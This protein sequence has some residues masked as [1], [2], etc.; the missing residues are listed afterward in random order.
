MAEKVDIWEATLGVGKGIIIKNVL[1]MLIPVTV[2]ELMGAIDKIN[3]AE[4][5]GPLLDPSAWVDGARWKNA[6]EAKNVLEA[7]AELRKTLTERL[8]IT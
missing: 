5:I 4:T 2:E 3:R 8:P 7:L 6:G 1:S